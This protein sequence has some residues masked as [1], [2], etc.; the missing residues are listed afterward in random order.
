MSFGGAARQNA[1]TSLLCMAAK[2]RPCRPHEEATPDALLQTVS[3]MLVQ[4][5][6]HTNEMMGGLQRHVHIAM[7]GTLA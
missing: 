7:A 4:Q 5:Q 2:R 1:N 3:A 6:T